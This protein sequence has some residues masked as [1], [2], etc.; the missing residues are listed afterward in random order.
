MGLRNLQGV[1][2]VNLKIMGIPITVACYAGYRGEQEPRSLELGG[3]A[4]E[5]KLIRDRWISPDHRYFKIVD[6]DDCVY[7]IRHDMNARAW[8]LVYYQHPDSRR[9]N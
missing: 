2:R 9:R 4:I 6:G 8:E 5:V 1:S 7:I 3:H